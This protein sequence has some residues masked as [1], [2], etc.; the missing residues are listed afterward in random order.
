MDKS[1]FLQLAGVLNEAEEYAD[2]ADFTEDYLT[3]LDNIKEIN[4]I[5]NTKKWDNWMKVTDKNYITKTIKFSDDLKSN[6][7]LVKNAAN[8]LEQQM[9]KADQG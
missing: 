2:S 7:K 3:V 6:M 5:I 4:K 8:A 1:R 9:N